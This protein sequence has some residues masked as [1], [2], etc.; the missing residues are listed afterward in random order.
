MSEQ[1]V[2]PTS[3]IAV[4]QRYVAQRDLHC[5]EFSKKLEDFQSQT[6]MANREYDALIHELYAMEPVPALGV[7]LGQIIQPKDFGIVGY[8]LTACSTL[9][10]ALTR[11]GRFQTLVLSELSTQ[12][13]V[14]SDVIRHRWHLHGVDTQLSAQFGV[15]VFIT[16]YQSLIGKKIAPIKVGLPFD[17]PENPE[18]YDELFACPVEFNTDCLMVDVPANVMWMTI[19]SSDPYMRKIFDGQA[20]AMLKAEVEKPSDPF[21]AFF[22]NLQQHILMAMKDGDT[23]A[24]TVA[25]QMGYSTRSFYRILEEAGYSYRSIIS[26]LRRRLA[27]KY[28]LDDSLSY[29]DISMLLGYSEQSAFSR[30]FKDWMG[31]TPGEYRMGKT[32]SKNQNRH[33]L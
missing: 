3:F 33:S 1:A 19:T 32:G 28:L 11:Y 30:A 2:I 26:G 8:L 12:V 25:K 14:S 22:E 21:E 15:S 20:E 23:K 18:L 31:M 29:S 24:A 13:E 7:K 16:L 4:L 5:P 6:K 27:K 10:Q 9:G 17:A